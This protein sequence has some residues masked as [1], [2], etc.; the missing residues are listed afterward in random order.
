MLILAYGKIVLLN[1]QKLLGAGLKKDDLNI[2]EW[3]KEIGL[4]ELFYLFCEHHVDGDNLWSLTALD[5]KEMGIKSVGHRRKI[6]SAIDLKSKTLRNDNEQKSKLIFSPHLGQ[7]RQVTVMFCDLVGSTNLS[8]QMD[9]EDFRNFILSYQKEVSVVLQEYNGFLARYMGDGVLAYFGYPRAYEDDAERALDAALKIV[10]L[11]SEKSMGAVRIGLASGVTLIGDLAGIGS[12]QE[13]LAIGETPNLAA[14]LQ[15]HAASN[16]ILICDNTRRLTGL[17]FEYQWHGD[18]SIKGFQ[19]VKRVWQVKARQI[20][21]A[22]HKPHLPDLPLVGRE[23]QIRQM[24]NTA[25]KIAADK[26]G[27]VLN[28]I[29]EAGMGKSRL[30]EIFLTRL[31]SSWGVIPLYC[32]PRFSKTPFYPLLQRLQR[33]AHIDSQNSQNNA[34]SRI[35]RL[36][37]IIFNN[38]R[39]A[40]EESGDID[41]ISELFSLPSPRQKAGETPVFPANQKKSRLFDIFLNYLIGGG[42]SVQP[43]LIIVEDTH[44]IDPTTKQLLVR[45]A[46]QIKDRPLFLIMTRRDMGRSNE[47]AI[48]AEDNL[49]LERLNEEERK[50]YINQLLSL[51]NI[52]PLSAKTENHLIARSGGVP[53]YLEELAREEIERMTAD[54]EANRYEEE[55]NIGERALPPS[56]QLSITARLDRLGR[57]AWEVVGLISALGRESSRDLLSH[58]PLA[59]DIR[60]DMTLAKLVNSG[61]FIKQKEGSQERHFFR[62]DLI[63]EVVYSMMLRSTRKQLHAQIGIALEEH[64]PTLI[65]TDPEWLAY[66]FTEGGLFEQALSLWERAGDKALRQSGLEEAIHHFQQA[67]DLIKK[68]EDGGNTRLAPSELR[69]QTKIGQAW[70]SYRGFGSIEVEQAFARARDLMRELGNESE[71]FPALAGQWAVHSLRASPLQVELGEYIRLV[72]ET[73]PNIERQCIAYIVQG[74]TKT[75]LGQFDSSIAHLQAAIQLYNEGVPTDT[76]LRYGQ[77]IGASALSLLLWPL[78]IRGEVIE[79]AQRKDELLRLVRK[80]GHKHTI[81]YALWSL[82]I[83]DIMEEDQISLMQRQ[84]ELE[85]LAKEQN[86]HMWKAASDIFQGWLFSHHGDNEMGCRIMEKGIQQWQ[87]EAGGLALPYYTSLV[88]TA[89]AN[90]GKAAEAYDRLTQVMEKEKS[91]IQSWLKPEILRCLGEADS[92]LGKAQQAGDKFTEAISL[93]RFQKAIMWEAKIILS[94]ADHLYRLGNITETIELLEQLS[95]NGSFVRCLGKSSLKKLQGLQKAIA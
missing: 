27:Q 9:S 72:A 84:Q 71:N 35:D 20:T 42:H 41:L 29:A 82:G 89:L 62:H 63:Q 1:S 14:R 21:E 87:N 16:Q 33:L 48:T 36:L 46:K 68:L 73:E 75:V 12:A 8:S 38:N 67:L 95:E 60:L 18:L 54:I 22:R 23:K 92:F 45:L 28:I 43:R 76:A 40:T 56:L 17:Q 74:A 77:D 49:R 32:H 13:R 15:S 58:M 31:D 69:L 11:L 24:L 51:E 70:F 85:A 64:F 86:S 91:S 83:T 90:N 10:K 3:L 34:E 80:V 50:I 44:W 30:I 94:R 61:I 52:P 26:Q 93:A 88:A 57:D 55:K 79:L 37:D 6:L 5:L 7:K 19:G 66:H 2:L 81:C 78:K 53:L 25:V 59:A 39:S 4:E 47:M 65:E